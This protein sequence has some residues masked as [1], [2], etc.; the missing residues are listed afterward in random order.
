MTTIVAK[1]PC[2]SWREVRKTMTQT[3]EMEIDIVRHGDVSIVHV[4]GDVNWETSPKL[5]AAILNLIQKRSQKR[6]I[7]DLKGANH[8]DSSGIS[9]FVEVLEAAKKAGARFILSGLSEA[10]RRVL[11]LTRLNTVFEATDTVEQALQ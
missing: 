10:S 6:V 4:R 2:G 5:R 9:S 8:I 7:T 11:E 3:R 1:H